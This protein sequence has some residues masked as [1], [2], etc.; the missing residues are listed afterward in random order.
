[1]L[2]FPYK[3]DLDLR[4]IPLMTL[5]VCAL[6]I[7][8]YYQQVSRDVAISHS[9]MQFCKQASD[10]RL[11][12]LVVE[13]ITGERSVKRCADT[14]MTIHSSAHPQQMINELAS[15]AMEFE[16]MSFKKGSDLINE[17]LYDKY[18]EFA[19]QAP[20]SITAKLMYEPRSFEITKML[21]AAFAH[22]S[23]MHLLGNL[24]FFFA[25]AA[26]V[27]IILG[28]ITFIAVVVALALGTHIIYS[29]VLFS[30]PNALPT[31]GLSG[32]VMG[33]IALFTF[34]IPTARIRCFFWF[35]FIVR[36]FVIPGWILALWYIGWD[37]FNLY[38]GGGTPNVNLIAHVSGAAIGLCMGIIFFR[39]QRPILRSSGRI[40]RV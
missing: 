40:R 38:S 32:V 24:F 10:D 15:N 9:A 37:V 23:V 39:K 26:S 20:P 19:R 12:L 25:F 33:M 30:D 2:F 31:L 21:S 29:L 28:S 17:V 3:V 8:I 5:L 6:C 11:L 22:G 35:F 27:E 13:K 7:S 1:M 34:L 18:S 4:R 14:L 36:I 16:T